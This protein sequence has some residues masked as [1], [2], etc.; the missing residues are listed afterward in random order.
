MLTL[1]GYN[2]QAGWHAF[3]WQDK[4]QIHGYFQRNKIRHTLL[5]V[6]NKIKFQ[7]YVEIPTWLSTLEA[8]MYP[9][10]LRRGQVITYEDILD[11]KGN[12]KT[13]Q[14]LKDLGF[15]IEWWAYL[16][17]KS[18]YSKDLKEWGISRWKIEELDKILLG[19]DEKLI[20]NYKVLLE[21][22]LEEKVKEMM[23]AWM[24]DFGYGINLDDW[25]ILWDRNRKITLAATYKENL[26]KMF[27]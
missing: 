10:L 19:A 21:C 14:E 15:Q 8:L 23:L 9:H 2:L 7:Y 6:W 25:Q 4:H 1:E 12:L 24:K 27:Y 26:L 16:Q 18:R 17:L 20:K 13:R 22:K 5:N 11:K 3:L